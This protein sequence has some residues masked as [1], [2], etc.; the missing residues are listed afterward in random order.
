[1]LNKPTN[2]PILTVNRPNASLQARTAEGRRWPIDD[3]YDDDAE[4]E[5]EEEEEE[6]RWIGDEDDDGNEGC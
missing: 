4:E 6:G 1:M 5:E 3:D 2:V